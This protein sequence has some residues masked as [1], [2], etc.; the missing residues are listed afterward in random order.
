MEW[1]ILD[2]R[3]FGVPQRRR[4]VFLVGHLGGDGRPALRAL[5]ESCC[6]DSP[7]RRVSWAHPPASTGSSVEVA[8]TLRSHPRPGSNSDGGLVAHAL[9][10]AHAGSATARDGATDNLVVAASLTSGSH[11]NSNTPGRRQED[12]T[13]IVVSTLQGGANGRGYRIDAERAAGHQLV[14]FAGSASEDGCA[15]PL[16][17][18]GGGT[19]TTDIDGGTFISMTDPHAGAYVDADELAE[20]LLTKSRLDP[21]TETY[22][23]TS[24]HRTQTPITEE[25]GTPAL[26]G[27]SGGM[28]VAQPTGLRRLTPVECERLMSWP[29]GWTA[30]PGLPASDSKRYAACGDGVV[31][32]VAEWIGVGIM[33]ALDI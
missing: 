32:N 18:G 1:R 24:F 25:E 27:T 6:G 22:V 4:R 7:P 11:P 13:N 26:G 8:G 19:R 3:Y 2:A 30:P 20:A 10:R 29:D 21:E 31:S 17:N 33:Q 16:L 15:A 14:P 23:A 28:G 12:D 9:T 5:C